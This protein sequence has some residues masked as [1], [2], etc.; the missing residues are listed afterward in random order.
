LANYLVREAA[1]FAI[2]LKETIVCEALWRLVNS[3][4][5]PDEHAVQ[6]VR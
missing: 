5:P 2:N 1:I 3:I 6:C 4:A